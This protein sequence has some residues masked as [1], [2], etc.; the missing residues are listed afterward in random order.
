MSINGKLVLGA[1]LSIFFAHQFGIVDR[2]FEC[3]LVRPRDAGDLS[4]LQLKGRWLGS[5]GVLL[6]LA[7]CVKPQI[8]IFAVVLLAIWACWKP[9]LISFAVPVASAA[10]SIM[11]APSLDQYRQWLASLQRRHCGTSRRRGAERC[12]SRKLSFRTT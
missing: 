10:V 4:G 8:S 1:G 3:L 5:P 9:L 12:Q 7:H 11:R 6:G 2:Q